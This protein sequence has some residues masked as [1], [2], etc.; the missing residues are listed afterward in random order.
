[1]YAL[2]N[3]QYEDAIFLAERYHA[4]GVCVLAVFMLEKFCLLMNGTAGVKHEKCV[5]CSFS[6]NFPQFVVA[7]F[8]VLPQWRGTTNNAAVEEGQRTQL[9]EVYPALCH[10]LLQT[11]RV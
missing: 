2:D 7:G 3:H 6:S 1:M 8:L 10:L 9:P 5:I 11:A 4:E